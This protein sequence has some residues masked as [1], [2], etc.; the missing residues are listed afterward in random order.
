MAKIKAIIFDIGGVLGP[1][2]NVLDTHYKSIVD[3]TGLTTAEIE[4]IFK[5]HWPK[6]IVGKEKI[7]EFWAEVSKISRKKVTP[8]ELEKLYDES[9]STY[10]EVIKYAQSLKEKGYHLAILSNVSREWMNLKVHKFGLDKIFEKIFCSCFLGIAKP[11]PEIYTTVLTDLELT[12]DEAVFIDDREE[13]VIS[14][15][16]VGIK[17]VLYTDLNHLKADLAKLGVK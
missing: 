11:D 1:D 12:A 10:D 14:A 7:S 9:M 17:A 2:S 16:K 5:E 8:D 15:N 13:N 6:I 4:K 3:K